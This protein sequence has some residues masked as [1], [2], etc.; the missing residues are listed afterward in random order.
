MCVKNLE[1]LSTWIERVIKS[2]LYVFSIVECLDIDAR[3]VFG[4][5]EHNVYVETLSIF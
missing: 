3:E 2:E 1:I 4:I 5:E